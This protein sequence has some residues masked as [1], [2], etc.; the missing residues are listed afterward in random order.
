MKITKRQLRKII[1]EAVS[2]H[3]VSP[4]V[5][6]D[7]LDRINAIER[8]DRQDHLWDIV[9]AI[10]SGAPDW[11]LGMLRNNL[12]DAEMDQR[13]PEGAGD[14]DPWGR[15]ASWEDDA[16]WQEEERDIEGRPQG[17]AGAGLAGETAEKTAADYKKHPEWFN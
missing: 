17:A 12:E 5:T 14:E 11:T 16:S 2:G 1:R 13:D 6:Q 15:G 9:D 10:E 8:P 4:V 7:L 3:H